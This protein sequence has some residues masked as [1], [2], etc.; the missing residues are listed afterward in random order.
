MPVLIEPIDY[1]NAFQK[2]ESVTIQ[3]RR[4]HLDDLFKVYNLVDELL[5]SKNLQS[6]LPYAKTAL[7]EMVQNAVKATQKRV[8]FQKNGWDI[9]KDYQIGMKHFSE[10]MQDSKNMP[11]PDGILFSAE[12]QFIHKAENLDILVR[13]YGEMTEQEKKN[14]EY[15]FA[16][17]SRMKSVQELLENEVKQKEGGG[18][19]ISMILVLGK[20]LKIANPLRFQTQS[21]F[22]E[23]FLTLPTKQNYT[24][25]RSIDGIHH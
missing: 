19:G 11:L 25:Q 3:Y 10:Y 15:M 24:K 12:I 21:G 20:S 9:Q 22:T 5:I 23:F 1:L 2:G 17:G 13:N 14:L 8:Y 4:L 18:L 6:Y 7:K 16:R